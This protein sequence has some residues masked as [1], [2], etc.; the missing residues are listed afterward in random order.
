MVRAKA[1]LGHVCDVTRPFMILILCAN[2]FNPHGA[3]QPDTKPYLFST[4][5]RTRTAIAGGRRQFAVTRRNCLH[6]RT[7]HAGARPGLARMG[8][9]RQSTCRLHDVV[10]RAHSGAR[11]PNPG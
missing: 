6:S 1:D 11:S 8:S 4:V 9:E 5:V 10:R 7:D 2:K 3:N